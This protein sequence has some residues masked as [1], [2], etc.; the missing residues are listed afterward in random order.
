MKPKAAGLA[1]ALLAI[2][3]GAAP[4]C[5]ED[6]EERLAVLEEAFDDQR[7][8]L[9]IWSGSWAAIYSAVAISQTIAAATTKGGDS[10]RGELLFGA[11]G[12]AVGALSAGLLPLRFTV[13][14]RSI[15][16]QWDDPDR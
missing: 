5:R 3:A 7:L 16:A 9:D 13:P 2:S 15:R 8:G 11:A 12:A 10:A 1:F 4:E 6:V 14:L